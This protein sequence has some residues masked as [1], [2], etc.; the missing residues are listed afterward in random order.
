MLKIP[1]LN[2][3]ASSKLSA[4]QSTGENFSV[5]TSGDK[6]YRQ[7][8]QAKYELLVPNFRRETRVGNRVQQYNLV[9]FLYDAVS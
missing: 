1:N 5:K 8:S 7:C 3:N 9:I 6:A 2:K 4:E